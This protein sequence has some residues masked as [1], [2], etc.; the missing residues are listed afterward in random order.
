M[1]SHNSAGPK[2][3]RPRSS[4][5]RAKSCEPSSSNSDASSLQSGLPQHFATA[6]VYI[7]NI[8]S[9]ST[10][11]PRLDESEGLRR[12]SRSRKERF[13]QLERTS[14]DEGESD[15]KPRS[16]DRSGPSTSSSRSAG[17][18]SPRKRIKRTRDDPNSEVG[19][20]Y[21]HLK[22]LP[23]LFAVDNDIMF[24]G[25][26]PGVK[27]SHSGH[28]FAH[29]SNHFYPSLYL[30]G[31]TQQ[32]MKPEQDVDF[33]TLR[34]MSL[35]LTNLAGRPT[36]EGSELLPSELIAGVP[37]LLEKVQK[38]R[39]RTV[40]FVGKGIS[41]AFVKGLKQAGAVS[42]SRQQSKQRSGVKVEVQDQ[43]TLTHTVLDIQI[44]AGVLCA[45]SGGAKPS[46]QRKPA[47]GSPKAK[48]PL[49]T[50]DSAKDDSGYGLLP[51]CLSHAKRTDRPLRLD[52][53][54]LFFVSP[55]S[56]ARVTT[57][58]LD[59]KARILSSLRVLVEHLKSAPA[60]VVGRRDAIIKDEPGEAE[61]RL[62]QV[63]STKRVELQMVDLAAFDLR[64]G[65]IKPEVKQEASFFS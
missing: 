9:G 1:P 13:S 31:I 40:C 29:R 52:E 60:S 21:A 51:L 49:Y 15:R 26:N 43:D 37:V 20:I 54:T 18:S 30:S 14:E 34:P 5:S 16:A 11:S 25:I 28:H 22:G 61:Q 59:D 64:E 56:S 41:E 2:S 62:S 38:W 47:P 46:S 7:D 12:S 32:R 45:D 63:V 10:R 8:A 48:R 39:P 42:S 27:S 6:Y 23:D 44:P 24:C 33:P 53:V 17:P 55:S 35:G 36:A 4:N 65:D 57:H 3:K 58:F 19:S 50:K